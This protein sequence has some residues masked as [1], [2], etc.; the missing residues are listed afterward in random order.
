MEILTLRVRM[1][2]MVADWRGFDSFVQDFDPGINNFGAERVGDAVDRVV[3]LT[4]LAAEI[5]GRTGY[6]DE[7]QGGAI[8]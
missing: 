2:Q 7:P 8:P 4:H 1:T 6:G 3:D 5:G